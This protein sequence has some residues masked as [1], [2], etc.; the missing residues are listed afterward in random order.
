MENKKQLGVIQ[1][2]V[3]ITYEMFEDWIVTALEGGSNYWY[4][5]KDGAIPKSS[6][7]KYKDENLPLSIIF[8]K[9]IWIDKEAIEIHD[10]ENNE[11][12]GKI[13]MKSVKKALENICDAHQSIFSALMN[14][15]YDAVDADVFFQYAVMGEITFG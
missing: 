3:S 12:L 9:A 6:I 1:H 11:P 13:D 8:C 4:W 5:L 14:Q 15:E 7:E 2:N 10:I